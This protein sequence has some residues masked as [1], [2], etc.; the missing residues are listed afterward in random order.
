MMTATD[1]SIKMDKWK[2]QTTESNIVRF[3][4]NHGIII[5]ISSLFWIKGKVV[6]YF[7]FMGIRNIN[8]NPWFLESAQLLVLAFNFHS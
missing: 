6:C 4:K 3:V 2:Q 8:S 1:N 7:L 5:Q